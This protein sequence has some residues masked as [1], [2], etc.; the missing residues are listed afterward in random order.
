MTPT[1]HN[2]DNSEDETDES[3]DEDDETYSFVDL[4]VMEI[5]SHVKDEIHRDNVGRTMTTETTPTTESKGVI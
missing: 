3:W 1:D 4:P 5:L 2:P